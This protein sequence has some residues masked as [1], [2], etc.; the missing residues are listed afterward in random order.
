MSRKYSET[1]LPLLSSSFLSFN[2]LKSTNN[3][4]NHGNNKN[5]DNRNINYVHFYYFHSSV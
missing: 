5:L 3:N 1:F 2:V 4:K